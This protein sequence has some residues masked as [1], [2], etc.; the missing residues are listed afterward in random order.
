M[1]KLTNALITSW[2]AEFQAER[3]ARVD[4]TT[5]SRFFGDSGDDSPLVSNDD[6]EDDE[7]RPLDLFLCEPS[8]VVRH[9]SSSSDNYD[10]HPSAS[11]TEAVGD[12]KHIAHDGHAVFVVDPFITPL[13]ENRL[14]NLLGS[15]GLYLEALLELP[16][17]YHRVGTLRMVLLIAGRVRYDQI[18][19][20]ELTNEHQCRS[21]ISNFAARRSGNNLRDGVL[22]DPILFTSF[23]HIKLAQQVDHVVAHNEGYRKYEI[24]DLVLEINSASRGES[25]DTAENSLYISKHRSARSTTDLTAIDQKQHANTLQILVKPEFDAGFIAAFLASDLGKL[26][27]DEAATGA[28]IQRLS[29]D[30]LREILV[31]VPPLPVQRQI[32]TTRSNLHKLQNAIGEF[33]AELALN[34]ESS[35]LISE[36]ISGMLDSIGRLSRE[37][38]LRSLIRLGESK[39]SEFKETLSLDVRKSEATKD[40]KKEKDIETSALKT[41]AAF[42]NS[43]GGTLLVG[44]N[45]NGEVVGLE[46]EMKHFHR[47]SKDTLLLHFK[48]IFSRRIGE[49]FYPFIDQVAIDLDGKLILAITCQ[50]SRDACFLD[51]GAFFVRTNPATDQ[52]NG[53]KMI[54]YIGTR[55]GQS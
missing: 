14:L 30:A 41:L 19:V 38:S 7:C 13:E 16:P 2:I 48:N 31:P 6:F 5:N 52:L 27:L 12:A 24:R 40:F 33:A 29:A 26:Q 51:D 17:G 55:F 1:P 18:F 35:N 4:K 3:V 46:R 28:T 25:L 23:M 34:P 20:G 53:R 8:R 43:E 9:G 22:L 44:V 21:L 11:Y 47:N 42:M 37:D 36:S 10:D 15:E 50:P 39:T 54:D 45:D 32:A 49:T